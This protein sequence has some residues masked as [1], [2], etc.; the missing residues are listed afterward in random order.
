MVSE[1]RFQGE[2]I[3]QAQRKGILFYTLKVWRKR[4]EKSANTHHTCV[5][6]KPLRV[7]ELVEFLNPNVTYQML[8]VIHLN[9]ILLLH[10]ESS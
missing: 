2:R 5:L 10:K 7:A 1:P 8:S 4:P 3:L 9:H 6:V